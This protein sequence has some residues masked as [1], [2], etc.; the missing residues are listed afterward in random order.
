[1]CTSKKCPNRLRPSPRCHRRAQAYDN[2]AEPYRAPRA[3][4]TGCGV[5]NTSSVPLGSAQLTSFPAL[6]QRWRSRCC[7]HVLQRD[8]AARFTACAAVAELGHGKPGP[9]CSGSDAFMACRNPSNLLRRTPIPATLSPTD[10]CLSERVFLAGA[11]RNPVKLDLLVNPV[12]L[13]Q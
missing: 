10:S 3:D 1:M 5:R 7:S 13:L 6:R 4:R 2:S 8:L 9:P 11:A 12:Q